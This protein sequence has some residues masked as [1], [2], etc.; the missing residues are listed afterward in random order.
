[1]KYW[2]AA[3]ILVIGL[4]TLPARAGST[5]VQT[6]G[7]NIA[8]TECNPHRHTVAQ[9]HPWVDPYGVVHSASD[10]PYFDAFLGITYRNEAKVEATEVDFGLVARGSLIAVTRDVGRFSPGVVIDHE[11]VVSR[12]IFPIG[13]EFPECAVLQVKYADGTQ[14]RNPTPPEP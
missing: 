5:L 10:F 1:M 12:E 4:S 11:F 13:T 2:I 9:A 6:P 7:S 14:W 8:V 3:P